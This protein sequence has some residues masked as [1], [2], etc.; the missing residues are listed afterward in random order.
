LN[1]K[2]REVELKN[3]E[4]SRTR[5]VIEF[6][7]ESKAIVAEFL[8]ADAALLNW[9]I[10]KDVEAILAGEKEEIQSVA[11]RTKITIRKSETI[12]EDSFD[13]EYALET[14]CLQTKDFQALLKEWFHL[15]NRHH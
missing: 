4:I 13:D 3:K 15:Q 9:Q 10:I 5:T 2:I 7:D 1:Y 12:I 6:E 11:N 8:M 14:V